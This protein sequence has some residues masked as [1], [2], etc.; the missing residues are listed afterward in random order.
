MDVFSLDLVVDSFEVKII[1]RK[2]LNN[3]KKGLPLVERGQEYAEVQFL[4]QTT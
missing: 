1:S 3:S 4:N 2:F